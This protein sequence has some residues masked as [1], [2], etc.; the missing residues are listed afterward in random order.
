MY[1]LCI[2]QLRPHHSVATVRAQNIGRGVTSR[3][4]RPSLFPIPCSLLS[5]HLVRRR[6]IAAGNTL[7]EQAQVAAQLSAMVD[8]VIHHP[9]AP[10][11]IL[12]VVDPDRKSTR[13]NSS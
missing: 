4:P 3:P 12:R 9:G 10:D 11:V 1:T 5:S 6:P 2:Q 7:V 13:L 8:H